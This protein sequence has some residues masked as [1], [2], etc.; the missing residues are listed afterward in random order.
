MKRRYALLLPLGFIM[1]ACTSAQPPAPMP[2]SARGRPVIVTT[3]SHISGHKA[4]TIGE[5]REF[6]KNCGASRI[7]KGA[8]AEFPGADAVTDYRE[9][10]GRCSVEITAGGEVQFCGFV[11][12]AKV[13]RFAD[14][15]N[16]Q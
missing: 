3:A 8:L 15:G 13:A 7:A 14:V 11:C 2:L 12:Q 9:E 1:A 16:S 6:N 5:V 4:V 10:R